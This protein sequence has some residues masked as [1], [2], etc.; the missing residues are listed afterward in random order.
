MNVLGEL[1]AEVQHHVAVLISTVVSANSPLYF[2]NYHTH[3]LTTASPFF[4]QAEHGDIRSTRRGV[5]AE[6]FSM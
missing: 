2:V 1:E 6:V 4:S 3:M 5:A